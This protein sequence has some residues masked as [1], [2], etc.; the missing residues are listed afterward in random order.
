MTQKL[1]SFSSFIILQKVVHALYPYFT[2]SCTRSLPVLYTKLY[3]LSTGTLHK[4]EDSEARSSYIKSH[5]TFG[6]TQH[7]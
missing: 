7:T 4:T 6:Y 3:M 2:Q 5:L 1:S